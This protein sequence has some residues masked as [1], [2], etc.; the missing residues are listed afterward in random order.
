MAKT[1]EDLREHLFGALDALRDKEAPMD[2]DRA[3]AISEVARTVIESAK[4]EVEYLKATG[5]D[6]LELPV[7]AS[8]KPALPAPEP[9]QTGVVGIRTHRLKG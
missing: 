9:G 1:L 3:K 4:T 7:F 5:Q 6:S 2:I 8:A